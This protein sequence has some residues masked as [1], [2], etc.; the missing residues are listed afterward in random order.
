M[1]GHIKRAFHAYSD[2]HR[3]LSAIDRPDR[4]AKA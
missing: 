4:K 2:A 1:L 3:G